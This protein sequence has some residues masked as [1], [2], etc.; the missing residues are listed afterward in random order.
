MKYKVAI[1]DNAKYLS[2]RKRYLSLSSIEQVRLKKLKKIIKT[3]I[4]K[5]ETSD[6]TEEKEEITDIIDMLI[7]QYLS[8]KVADDEQLEKCARFD[9]TID[10]FSASDCKVFFRF[11]KLDLM[12]LFPLLKLYTF[13]IFYS[14]LYD[15]I[16]HVIRL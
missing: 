4:V 8:I 3:F 15:P 6:C 13:D 5:L 10:S 11:K 1:R 16:S 7:C 2:Y 12:R 14:Y 9:R